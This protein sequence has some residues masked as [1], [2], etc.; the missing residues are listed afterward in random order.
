MSLRRAV[1]EAG[2]EEVPE[3]EGEPLM[4]DW[5]PARGGTVSGAAVTVVSR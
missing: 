5:V 1:L 2:A 3:L 4:L